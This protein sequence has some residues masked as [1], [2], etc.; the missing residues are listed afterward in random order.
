M[1]VEKY[2][3]CGKISYTL[4]VTITIELLKQ[5]REAVNAVF[6]SSSIDREKDGF[7]QILEICIREN[8]PLEEND[9]AFNILSP[10]GNCFAIGEFEKYTCRMDEKASHIVLVNPS[11]AGNLGTI[12]R[13]SAGFGFTNIAVI[14]PAA[15]V[16][17]PKAVRSSMG[18]LFH[19]NFQYFDTFEQYRESFGEHN[20]YPFML[21]SSV[22]LK[23]TELKEPYAL[24]FGNE[25]TGLPDSFSELGRPVV[26]PHSD[27]I[28]SLNLPIAVSIAEYEASKNNWSK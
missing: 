7:K 22:P 13:T 4:G 28:D 2:K 5:R 23:D 16:F 21:T 1:K 3:K 12:L 14:R 25:A 24:V 18:A 9:K 20:L 15:D 19:I 17:D 8:V 6:V 11:D 26:I 10:K 27:R